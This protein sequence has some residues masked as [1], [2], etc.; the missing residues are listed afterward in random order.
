MTIL[1][2]PITLERINARIAHSSMAE[3]M[4]LTASIDQNELIFHLGFREAHIG[5]PV[6]RAIHGGVVSTF[7]ETA[8]Y[9]YTFSSLDEDVNIKTTSIHTSFLRSTSAIDMHCR[10]NAQRIGRRFGFL[11]VNCWQ[12]ESNKPVASA[13]VGIRILRPGE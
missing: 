8:A 1:L 9:L 7:M 2:E 5:N 11:T 13:E 3:W 12:T 6:I 10:V 4:S